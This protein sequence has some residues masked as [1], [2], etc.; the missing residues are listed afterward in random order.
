MS[1]RDEL[2]TEAASRVRGSGRWQ[3][4]SCPFCPLRGLGPDHRGNWCL[5]TTRG[6]Y[7][8]FRCNVKGFLPGCGPDEEQ[9]EQPLRC[10]PVRMLPGELDDSLGAPEGFRRL[11]ERDEDLRGAVRYVRRRGITREIAEA[12][13]LGACLDGPLRGRIVVPIFAADGRTWAG[14]SAR[15]YVPAK[16][17]HTPKYRTPEGMVKRKAVYNQ[18]ALY[19]E[20]DEPLLV[21]EGAFDALPYYPNALALLGKPTS[22]QV[23]LLF[24]TKRP[25][26]ICLDGDAWLEG[27]MLAL[28]LAF[29]GLSRVGSVRLPPN[30]DPNSVNPDWLRK[31]ASTAWQKDLLA[32]AYPGTNT[33]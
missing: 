4:C 20:T 27:Q 5:D 21:V 14:W 33:G 28:R 6:Y 31:K 13:H 24:D 12:A 15:L 29:M 1:V 2:A 7:H 3:R 8:C 16:S 18:A 10:L 23:D 11:I 30:T 25:L 17:H 9:E 22:D 26:V 19:R 32:E